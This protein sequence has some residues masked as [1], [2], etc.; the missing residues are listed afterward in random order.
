MFLLRILQVPTY[1]LIKI[2]FNYFRYCIQRNETV[3]SFRVETSSKWYYFKYWM[4]VPTIGNV[5]NLGIYV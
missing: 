5:Y 3:Y 1:I 2:K 4:Y